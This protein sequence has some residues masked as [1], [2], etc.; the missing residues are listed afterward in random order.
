MGVAST[1]TPIATPALPPAAAIRTPAA[2]TTPAPTPTTTPA[3]APTVH[4]VVPLQVQ[5]QQAL[6]SRTAPLLQQHQQPQPAQQQ[7]QHASAPP[8][9]AATG[10]AVRP[11]VPTAAAAANP[12]PAQQY[13]PTAATGAIPKTS[14][15]TTQ[16]QQQQRQEEPSTG[17]WDMRSPA[18]G[19]PPKEQRT[20]GPV[21]PI[22]MPTNE[23]WITMTHRQRTASRAALTQRN[24]PWPVPTQAEWE[25][26]GKEAPLI[27]YYS[28]QQ[29]EQDRPRA[30][31]AG[32]IG[33]APG[34]ERARALP[35]PPQAQTGSASSDP[36]QPLPDSQRPLQMDA[37]GQQA[38]GPLVEEAAPP[39]D[40]ADPPAEAET[41]ERVLTGEEWR[42]VELS[43]R[44]ATNRARREVAVSDGEPAQRGQRGQRGARGPLRG[45]RAHPR[46]LNRGAPRADRGSR[47]ARGRP[48]LPPGIGSIRPFLKRKEGPPSPPAPSN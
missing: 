32:L 2:S 26:A 31:A 15:R 33:G 11:T 8:P 37:E 42:Q 24:M 12:A 1:Q 45:A 7:Q 22:A 36:S 39:A 48:G 40:A 5:R 21:G 35:H 3:P 29:Q 47:S 41:E 17:I 28:L 16:P 30:I 43:R 14:V 38:P 20:R 10:P 19:A 13:V 44:Q 18:A 27:Q 25:A 9:R 46:G 4:G 34:H 23:K 6:H